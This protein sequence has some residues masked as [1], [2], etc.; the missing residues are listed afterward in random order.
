[1][2]TG[3]SRNIFLF[4]LL[5]SFSPLYSQEI[6]KKE[7]LKAVKEADISFYYDEDYESAASQYENILKSYPE[8]SNISAKLGI[9]Y[10]NMDGKKTD[11]LKLLQKASLNITANDKDYLEYGDKAPLDTYL[12]LA[13]AYHQ[14]DSLQK[15]IILYNDAKRR[16]KNTGIFRVDYMDDQIRDCRYAL[17]ME[18]NP[19][20]VVSDLFVP[21]LKEYPGACNPVLSKNDSVFIFTQKKGG[22]TSIFCSYKT[23]TWKKPVDIT[24]QLGGND[25]FYSNS[26]TSDG[27]LL[28]INMNDGIDGNLYYSQRKDSAWTKIKSFGKPINSIYWEAFGF[29][30]PDGKSMYISSNR[31]GGEGELDIWFTEKDD[32]GKWKDPVN[33]G[34]TINTQYNENTP[35]FDQSSNTLMFSSLGHTGMGGYDIFRSIRKNGLWTTPIGLPYSFNNTSDNLF[36]ISDNNQN[37]I[38][39]IFYDKTGT[40]NI[41]S[42]SSGESPDKNIKAEGKISLQDGMPVDPVQTHIQLLDQKTG[43]ILKNISVTDTGSFNYLMK[44][45]R[46]K[47]LISRIGDKTDTI[48]LNVKKEARSESQTLYDTASFRF[49]IKPGDYQLFV[50]HVGYKTDTINLSIPTNHTGNYLAINS[51]L[52]PEKVFSGSFL[53]IKNLLFDFDSYDLTDKS[54]STLELLKS[55]LF[56]YP[57]LKIEVAGYTDSRGTK[58]YNMTLADKRAQVI[59]DY[60]VKSGISELRF[61]KKAFGNSGFVALNTNPDGSDNPE[62]RKYNRRVTFGIINPQTGVIIHQDSYTPDHLRQPNSIKYSI[63]LLKTN[64]N[65]S[66]DYFEKLKIDEYHLITDIKS[67]NIIHYQIGIFYNMDDA[68]RYLVYAHGKGFK[69]AYIVSQYDLSDSSQVFKSTGKNP[70]STPVSKL[71]TIQLSASKQKLNLKQFERIDGVKEIISK[72]G[73]FRYVCGEYDSFSAAKEALSRIQA[74]GFEKAFIR[75]LNLLINK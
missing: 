38:T 43:V 18:K 8:N 63:V 31:P 73:Y 44:P 62:G 59:I 50:N 26:I 75:N 41:Y 42:V 3:F 6:S 24:K 51:S 32:K 70:V 46:F 16:L 14:N 52:I 56:R 13:I 60:L 4:L 45:G 48:N 5:L 71:Y 55:I 61:V 12:Y 72:D 53:A 35:F 1:M 74:S 66:S 25:R 21:W 27:K 20:P 36:F 49:V 64:N 37:Y 22:K 69:D 10:L 11:A 68:S 30:T 54:I 40:R 57:Q 47:V 19:L 67:D 39:S 29:I 34:K 65:V 15:A 17:E 2:K 58:E 28:I 33:C 9:C 23:G 7:L